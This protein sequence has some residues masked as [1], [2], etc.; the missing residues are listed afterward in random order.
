MKNN[1]IQWRS[2]GNDHLIEIDDWIIIKPI[3]D[4][5]IEY[6]RSIWLLW[7]YFRKVGLKYLI[8]KVY[9]RYTEATRNRKVSGIGLGRVIENAEKSDLKVG[10]S[11]L[12]FATNHNDS[13]KIIPLNNQL[14][15]KWGSADSSGMIK[16]KNSKRLEF[17]SSLIKYIGWSPFSGE[18]IDSDE[19]S[20]ALE[21]LKK[22]LQTESVAVEKKSR[23]TPLEY[24]DRYDI[25]PK[26]DSKPSAVLFGL[27]NYAKTIIIPNIKKNVSLKRVH[28]LDPDQFNYF[29]EKPKVSLDTSPDP[30]EDLRFDAWFIAGYHH[31]HT[32]L[33]ISALS[34]NAY[35]VIEKPL[36]TTA[37]QFEKFNLA[38]KNHSDSNYFLCF[39]KRYSK[40]NEYLY[41]DFNLIKGEPIDMHSIVYEIP[42]PDLHWYNW[43]NSGSRLISNGCHWLDFFMYVNDYS[44]A[45]EFDIWQPKG[46]DLVVR[47]K[48][49]NCA[50]LN[51]SLT[52][53]GSK[54]LGVR[55]YIELRKK[56]ITAKIVDATRYT[57]ENEQRVLRDIKINP[58]D[59]YKLMYEEITKKIS[60]GSKGDSIKSLR[61][62]ELTLL[63]ENELR[64]Q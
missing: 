61:S 44:K 33:A 4:Q 34:Q 39:H 2:A 7:N 15:V 42:L 63:L 30:R 52:D 48:L 21:D 6:Q 62:S 56:G 8:Q 16:V 55:D 31:T 18:H 41:Q 19:I 13:R 5:Y 10:D 51:L 60:D 11:V 35:A 27:G 23:N 14:T 24:S 47:V 50:Y 37:E 20:Q 54:R 3:E 59:T 9:S 40:L 12:F 26:S 46:S 28:E 53:T 17:P 57:V 49:E 25:E 64:V 32:D 22:E 38:L 1:L 29:G 36:A 45:V 58:L 43:P